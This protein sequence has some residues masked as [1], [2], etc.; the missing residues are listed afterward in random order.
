MR[1]EKRF[2]REVLERFER[3]GRGTG[4]F[5]DYTAWHRVSRGDPAS[6]G[7]SH[8]KIYRG[9]HLDLLS[10]VEWD[11][12]FFATM[13]PNILD[14]TEQRKLSLH[15]GPHELAAYDVRYGGL[16]VP[17]TL[18]IAKQLGIK[19]PILPGDSRRTQWIMTT[20]QVL[21][22]GL[23]NGQLE[24]LPISHKS[25]RASLSKRDLQK[26]SI[27]HAYWQARSSQCLLITPDLFEES[28]ALTLRRT[29]C[30]GLGRPVK[31]QE[32]HAA[33]KVVHDT[34][35]HSYTYTWEVLSAALGDGDIANRA[36][37]QAVW[38][39]LL[40]IDLR[41]GWRPHLPI[42][43]LRPEDFKALNPVASRRSSWP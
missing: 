4:T 28:V 2:T 1:T 20:D 7:R 25:N 23:P 39:G 32:I 35:G 30:W 13:L 31:A 24:V 17:G 16:T 43:L 11:G 6:L 40:P 9:R 8:L 29:A 12:A 26:F 14:F 10:D 22:L 37:W 34:R 38:A 33:I 41:R 3:E 15:D 19:H 18:T 42:D 5:K 27:E 21:F 36:L